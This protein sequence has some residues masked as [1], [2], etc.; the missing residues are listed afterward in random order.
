MEIMKAAI[1]ADEF[2]IQ[3][4]SSNFQSTKSLASRQ[5]AHYPEI[6]E[7]I[8]VRPEF[9]VTEL[10]LFL[11]DEGFDLLTRADSTT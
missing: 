2:K 10:L 6:V 4:A 5:P 3:K 1:P 9:Q 8:A 7:S 11:R